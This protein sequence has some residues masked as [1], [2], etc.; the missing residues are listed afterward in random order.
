MQK[1]GDFKALAFKSLSRTNPIT[2]VIPRDYGLDEGERDKFAHIYPFFNSNDRITKQTQMDVLKLTGRMMKRDVVTNG[3]KN[4]STKH[5]RIP[6][7]K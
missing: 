5:K 3:T 1:P 4:I 2:L 7:T 6:N